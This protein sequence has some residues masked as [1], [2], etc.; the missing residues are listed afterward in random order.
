MHSQD[1]I[2]LQDRWPFH[3]FG[4]CTVVS[5]DS[6]ASTAHVWLLS[7]L[8]KKARRRRFHRQ[9]ADFGRNTAFVTTPN[10]RAFAYSNRVTPNSVLWRRVENNTAG[11]FQLTMRFLPNSRASIDTAPGP[12]IAKLAARVAK[13]M[14]IQG[15]PTRARTIV[16]SMIATI[17]PNTGVH[18]PTR[19]NIPVPAPTKCRILKAERG[20][21]PK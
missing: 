5:A 15:S 10:T 20:A 1:A 2:P 13:M 6:P 9:C 18:R 17:V 7:Q 16:T 14:E 8:Q 19:R 4:P 11:F 21:S 12:I 3:G